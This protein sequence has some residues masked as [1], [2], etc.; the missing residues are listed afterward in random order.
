[1][2]KDVIRDLR[3]RLVKVGKELYEHKLVSGT[4]G[5]I[6]AR[7]PDTNTM[8]IKPSGVCMGF[9]KPED[10]VI[11]DFDGKKIEGELSLSLET[12][13]H[14]AIYKARSD[15]NGIAHTHAPV[16]T[17]FGVAGI[18]ILPL[19]IEMFLYIPK[20]I[21]VVPFEFPGSEELAEAV[22][23]KIVDFNALILENHGIVTVG[24]TI[25][26][27]CTL[28]LMVEECAKVQFMATMLAGREAI[29]W[30][31]LKKKLKI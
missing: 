27:A 4:A 9:L 16:A 6:S 7:I 30:E 21:P 22:R 12:P 20:G 3:E 24:L 8:L 19:Q 18:E 25:E 26:E 29:N 2:D 23:K 1:V 14:T 11:V 10:L 28:N 17:A 5:N 13:M 31:N 15:I